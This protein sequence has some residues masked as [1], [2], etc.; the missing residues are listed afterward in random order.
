MSDIVKT[1][2]Y[3][4]YEND[5]F[6]SLNYSDGSCVGEFAIVNTRYGFQLK[7]YCDSWKI[8]NKC[9]NLFELLSNQ[10]M[11]GVTMKQLAEMI[12]DIGYELE[13]R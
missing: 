8:F 2:T 1:V 11:V 7:A 4:Q 5:I 13:I 6:V 3:S 12:R 9:S 10:S